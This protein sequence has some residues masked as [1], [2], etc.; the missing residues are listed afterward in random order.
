MGTA[1]RSL[2]GDE[3][4]AATAPRFASTI[5]GQFI[6]KYAALKLRR[7]VPTGT[8]LLMEGLRRE[9]Q[10]QRTLALWRR[11]MIVTARLKIVLNKRSR[12]FRC[13]N[14]PAR[15]STRRTQQTR[16]PAGDLDPDAAS[17]LDNS[18]VKLGLTAL[19]RKSCEGFVLGGSALPAQKG[20]GSMENNADDHPIRRCG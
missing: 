4:R 12:R 17:S 15:R 1:T 13:K 6:A 9:Q 11:A 19:V 16:A 8:A 5:F 7:R 3:E 14:R 2:L 18:K 20:A 10:R